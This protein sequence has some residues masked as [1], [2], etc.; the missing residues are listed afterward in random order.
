MAIY[1]GKR[2]AVTWPRGH[3]YTSAPMSGS[4]R[5]GAWAGMGTGWAITATMLGGIAA[6]GGL[7]YLAGLLFGT[8]RV[9]AAIGMVIGAVGAIY[10]VYLR[11]GRERENGGA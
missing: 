11:Y 7:G 4:G 1:L 2:P 8:E 5:D 10:V 6:W 3:G 9:F